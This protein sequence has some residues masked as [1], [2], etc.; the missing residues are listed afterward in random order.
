MAP[1]H[2]RDVPTIDGSQGNFIGLIIALC[3]I[4]VIACGVV[5]YLLRHH[6]PSDQDRTARRERFLRQREASDNA[7][8]SPT[9]TWKDKVSRL[10]NKSGSERRRGGRGWIQTGSGDEWD[11]SDAELG[12]RMG[13]IG[14]SEGDEVDSARIVHSPSSDLGG[15]LDMYIS[16]HYHDPFSKDS[17]SP[18][19]HMIARTMSP[20]SP[21]RDSSMDEVDVAP[22]DHRH[23]S[24]QSATSVRTFEGGTKFIESL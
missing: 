6:E 17:P 5:F 8:T 15:S 9:Q 14:S 20:S 19:S 11:P 18:T 21:E 24:T 7:S 1:A 3:A 12:G 13:R 2:Q 4:I 23:M 16:T 22:P 10:W